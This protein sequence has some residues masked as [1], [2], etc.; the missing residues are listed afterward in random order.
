[1][2]WDK[3]I[4][5]EQ[6]YEQS[7]ARLSKI[8]EADP[9]SAEGMEAALLVLLIEEYENEHYPISLPDP[10]E[11]VKEMMERKGL[12]DKDLIPFLGSK[13]T[14]SLV[15]TKKR[16][17]TIDMIR[18]L[19]EGLNLPVELLIQPYALEGQQKNECKSLPKKRMSQ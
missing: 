4:T 17:L 6:E 16:G 9:E 7:L 19:S 11:A 14:V 12:K 15:L 8:F 18:N 2:K 13:T 5:T 1:M 3:L 10:I